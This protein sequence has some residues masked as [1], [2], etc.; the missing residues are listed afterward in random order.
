MKLAASF[1]IFNNQIIS[2]LSSRAVFKTMRTMPTKVKISM[3]ST[4]PS[5]EIFLKEGY[6]RSLHWVFKIG[7]LM[8]DLEFYEKAFG[9]SVHRHEEFSSGCEATCN[10]PYGG[11]W[12]KTMVGS[13]SEENNFALELTYNY[14]IAKYEAGND[15]RYI[16][17]KK[18]AFE[19]APE[20]IKKAV[21][22]D[23]AGRQFISSPDGY[24]YMLV[25][26]EYGRPDEPFLFVSLHVE[27]LAKSK[28]FYIDLLDAELYD[29]VPG[30]LEATNSAMLS[31]V[32]GSPESVKLELVELPKGEKLEHKLASGRFATETEDG[33]PQKI[34]DRVKA[35]GGTILH[36]P[37]KLQPHNEEVVIVA[38]P[39]GHEFCFVDAR[40]YTNCMN[41]A[42]AQGGRTVDWEYRK[43]LNAAALKGGETAKLEIAKLSAGEYDKAAVTGMIQEWI[44]EP[45][46]V[47]SQTSCPYCKKAKELLTTV[48]ANFK[49]VEVDTLDSGY[50]VRVELSDM[51]GRSSVPNIFIGGKSVG[52]FSDGPGV[53]NLY[54]Q[55]TLEDML[56]KVGAL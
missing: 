33:A 5:K 40:G 18:S 2:R 42:Y 34:G 29:K 51:T 11:A 46:V 14:G 32:R 39:D 50:A 19:G 9:M 35:A 48:G 13:G 30:S 41:V 55:G 6:R 10:G 22:L 8:K 12:S 26:T 37:I 17:V 43:K 53:E 7:D 21:Y 16:A 52:G 54:N 3:T 36:G 4:F 25:D 1:E 23:D 31:F 45:V 27:D 24:K 20:A 47:F 15:L 49:V 56:K 28:K 38:D 44:K